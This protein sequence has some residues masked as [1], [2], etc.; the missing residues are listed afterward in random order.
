LH[1]GCRA[2]AQPQPDDVP[3]GR[4]HGAVRQHQHSRCDGRAVRP[5]EGHQHLPGQ[6]RGV[7]AYMCMYVCQ[8]VGCS[9]SRASGF[10]CFVHRHVRVVLEVRGDACVHGVVWCGCCRGDEWDGEV[11][12]VLFVYPAGQRLPASSCVVHGASSYA[13]CSSHTSPWAACSW[14]RAILD[15]DGAKETQN[16]DLV[17][18]E[19]L[20]KGSPT[21]IVVRDG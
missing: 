12:L 10:V 20:A 13:Q 21:C 16:T 11:K 9:K 19:S 15:T 18:Q 6:A 5:C 8:R 7:C 4:A 17:Q 14:L 1:A 3:A 2:R